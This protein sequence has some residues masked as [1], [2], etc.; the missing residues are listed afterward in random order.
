MYDDGVRR[1]PAERSAVAKLDLRLT[2]ERA[3]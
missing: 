2:A 3:F 1:V